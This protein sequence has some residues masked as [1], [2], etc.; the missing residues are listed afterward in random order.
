MKTSMHRT[1]IV[2]TFTAALTGLCGAVQATGP[3]EETTTTMRAP[4]GAE[5]VVNYADLDL[6]AAQGREALAHRITRA[7]RN[8]CGSTDHRV[9]GGLRAAAH[10]RDCA[11]EAFDDAMSRVASD[12]ALAARD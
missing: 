12:T 1:A 11:R 7:A 6:T 5:R 10:N 4:Q 2:A 3:A 8:V 9:A